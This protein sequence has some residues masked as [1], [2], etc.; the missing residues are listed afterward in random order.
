MPSH[1][2]AASAST[3]DRRVLTIGARPGGG[4]PVVQVRVESEDGRPA[5]HD[6]GVSDLPP[7]MYL[8]DGD[9]FVGTALARGPWDEGAAHGGPVAAMIGRAAHRHDPD[10]ELVTVR[11][12]IELLRPVPLAGIR[13]ETTTLRPGG[14]VRLLGVSVFDRTG[15]GGDTGTEVARATV[16]RIRA[17]DA[18]APSAAGPAEGPS[19]G[20]EVAL[21]A[22]SLVPGR[23]G[24]TNAVELRSAHGSAI[25]PGP[26][27]YWFRM[28]APLVDD[29]PISP[30]TR[31]LV[32][33]DFGNGIASVTSLDR[34]VFINP[35]LTVHVHRL[36]EGE[37]VANEAVTWLDPGGAARAD[38]VLHDQGGPLGRATQSLY[39]AAR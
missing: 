17:A 38:A 23:V 36:P 39:I 15:A 32:A 12:T 37:W 9:G 26:A 28:H 27:T 35:D 18:G 5:W 6:A 20:P 34:H 7:A 33:A 24:I 31:L 25:E 11:Y 19:I 1:S 8:S 14:R 2:R 3:L 22:P 30:L 21:D 29:E 13:I 16:L 10:P 4:N